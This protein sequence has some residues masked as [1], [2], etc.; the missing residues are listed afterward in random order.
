MPDVPMISDFYFTTDTK[1][2]NEF[3]SVCTKYMKDFWSLI[4]V[5]G[6]EKQK[7]DPLLFPACASDEIL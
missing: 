3:E 4:S 5:E 1:N 7:D 2:M 6:Y